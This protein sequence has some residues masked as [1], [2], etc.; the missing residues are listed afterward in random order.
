MRSPWQSIRWLKEPLFSERIKSAFLLYASKVWWYFAGFRDDSVYRY[1]IRSFSSWIY[2][3]SLG[4]Q[5]PTICKGLRPPLA[6]ITWRHWYEGPQ[7]RLIN[8]LNCAVVGLYNSALCIIA[9][10]S[11]GS[12]AS[13][14][15]SWNLA[16]S[17]SLTTEALCGLTRSLVAQRSCK[18]LSCMERCHYQIISF[19]IRWTITL[20][21]SV[22][23]DEK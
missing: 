12:I 1:N 6:P 4:G 17:L 8:T 22:E 2:C 11:A 13:C 18:F 3:F 15:R 19:V 23:T 14:H 9:A 16:S 10:V 7:N 21:S 20:C 5:T